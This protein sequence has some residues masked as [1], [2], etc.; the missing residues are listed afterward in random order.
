MRATLIVTHV[1]A[2]DSDEL[3]TA[4]DKDTVE[5]FAPDGAYPALEV[6]VR[7]WPL[8]RCG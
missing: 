4:E 6:G 8:K 7:G 1:D 3:S 5:A 2:Q